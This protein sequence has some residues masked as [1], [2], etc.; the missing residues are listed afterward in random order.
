MAL[1]SEWQMIVC[2]EKI[3]RVKTDMYRIGRETKKQYERGFKN[4]E[5][6]Y[7]DKMHRGSGYMEGSG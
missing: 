5:N 4:Y 3:M 2:G 7:L 1:Y 6:K